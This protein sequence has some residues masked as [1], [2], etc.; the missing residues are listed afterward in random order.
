[1]VSRSGGSG[2]DVAEP[3]VFFQAI[4]CGFVSHSRLVLPNPDGGGVW[5][6]WGLM[7]G[8]WLICVGRL[9]IW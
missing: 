9:D 1:M 4:Y 8:L 3:G 5:L 7:R 2:I 6:V